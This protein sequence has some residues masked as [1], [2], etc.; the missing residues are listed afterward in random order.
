M[1]VRGAHTGGDEINPEAGS[2]WG[3]FSAEWSG[4]QVTDKAVLV[5]T[6]L[7][8]AGVRDWKKVRLSS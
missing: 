5:S 2:L 7:A 1:S 4:Q 8:V 3:T 6:H